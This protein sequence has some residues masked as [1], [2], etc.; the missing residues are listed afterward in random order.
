[1]LSLLWGITSGCT[2]AEVQDVVTEAF[3]ACLED[4]DAC[5]AGPAEPGLEAWRDGSLSVMAFHRLPYGPPDSLHVAVS[6][7]EGLGCPEVPA[8]ADVLIS[9]AFLNVDESFQSGPC[10]DARWLLAERGDHTD[11]RW[12]SP[13][14]PVAGELVT[15][16]D[17]RTTLDARV[18]NIS[19]PLAWSLSSDEVAPGGEV[20]V[21]EQDSDVLGLVVEAELNC[22]REGCPLAVDAFVFD[23]VV[24]VVIPEGLSRGAAL[25]TVTAEQRVATFSCAFADCSAHRVDTLDFDLRITDGR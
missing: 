7:A 24:R 4:S 8:S 25:L 23:G 2:V 3:V 15:L 19:S 9:D 21:G 11:G 13:S 17:G 14:E 10:P 12:P 5:G 6:N 18:G 22:P 1:M 20:V 16:T